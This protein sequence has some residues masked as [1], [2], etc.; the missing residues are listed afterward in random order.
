MKKI[1]IMD[2]KKMNRNKKMNLINFNKINNFLHILIIV[3]MRLN[4]KIINI[5]RV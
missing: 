3:K 5:K 1:K 4:N 2:N